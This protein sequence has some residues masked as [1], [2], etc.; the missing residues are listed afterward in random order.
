[1]DDTGD[2]TTIS[3]VAGQCVDNGDC[4]GGSECNVT[5]PGGICGSCMA[6]N[7]NCAPN[8]S[9]TAYG[10][11]NRICD[12]DEDCPEGMRCS[13]TG[14]CA[15]EYCVGGVCPSPLFGCPDDND[16][17][18]CIRVDCSGGTACPTDTTCT[19]GVCVENISL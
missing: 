3:T 10:S 15:V 8:H 14:L 7:D 13:G 19:N 11:C 6:S 9:C 16:S 4:T 17:G 5:A 2:D 12:Y 1:G 18:M